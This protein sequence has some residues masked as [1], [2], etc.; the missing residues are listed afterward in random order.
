MDSL[1]SQNDNRRRVVAVLHSRP[2][3]GKDDGM[4]RL[5][6]LQKEQTDWV[7]DNRGKLKPNIWVHAMDCR[8]R[9]N[10]SVTQALG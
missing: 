6:R 7:C 1:E 3:M 10:P 4:G 5:R 9:V 2:V 8:C